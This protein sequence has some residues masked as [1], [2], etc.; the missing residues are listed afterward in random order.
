[1]LESSG[2]QK[3]LFHPKVKQNNAKH[4]I[5]FS[6]RRVLPYFFVPKERCENNSSSDALFDPVDTILTNYGVSI[7]DAT[8]QIPHFQRFSCF[9]SKLVYLQTM[10]H[11]FLILSTLF[12]RPQRRFRLGSAR[13]AQR[14]LA[15]F[16]SLPGGARSQRLLGSV[17]LDQTP[18]LWLNTQLKP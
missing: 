14:L 5:V 2:I 10:T 8:W 3:A 7:P 4:R 17:W 11:F 15:L 13:R 6:S 1:M 16:P 18:T 9:F 12:A